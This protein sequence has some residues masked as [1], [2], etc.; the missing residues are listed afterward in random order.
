MNIA[1]IQEVLHRQP[2]RPFTLRLADGR[3]LAIPHPDFIAV[4]PR[5]VVVINQ[6]DSFA[7]LEPLLIV[8]IEGAPSAPTSSNGS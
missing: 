5:T 1:A 6:D 4:S 7:I 3:Q 8:S 2:F